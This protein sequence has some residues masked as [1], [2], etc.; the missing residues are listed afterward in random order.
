VKKEG[1][2][3][4]RSNRACD[5]LWS[6]CLDNLGESRLFKIAT[7][8]KL[9]TYT[10]SARSALH[11]LHVDNMRWSVLALLSLP[12][13]L[14]ATKKSPLDELTALAAAGNGDIKI[15]S[16]RVYDLLTTPHRNW[17]ASIHFTALDKR[18]R[19]APCK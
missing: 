3:N 1:E 9:H 18:R 16:E 7:D 11:Y 8:L 14:A 2:R 5:M 10:G 4:S 19:C 13:C 12:F 17:S 6:K 15:I